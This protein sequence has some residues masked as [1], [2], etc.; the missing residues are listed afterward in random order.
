V[1]GRPFGAESAPC[2]SCAGRSGS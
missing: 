2:L 1:D